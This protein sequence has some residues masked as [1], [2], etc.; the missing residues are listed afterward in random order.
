M[1]TGLDGQESDLVEGYGCGKVCPGLRV[2]CGAQSVVEETRGRDRP[3]ERACPDW[4]SGLHRQQC[5][6]T[7]SRCLRP[8]DWRAGDRVTG[9]DRGGQGAPGEWSGQERT[10]DPGS[11]TTTAGRARRLC[12]WRHLHGYSHAGECGACGGGVSG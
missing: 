3:I 12:L 10:Q 1:G 2:G 7:D 5:R 6:P 8:A 9:G 4:S 11:A